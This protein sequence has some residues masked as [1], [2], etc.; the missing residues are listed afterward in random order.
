[1]FGRILGTNIKGDDGMETWFILKIKFYKYFS[2]F[3]EWLYKRGSGLTWFGSFCFRSC[4]FFSIKL[5]DTIYDYHES[6]KGVI[7]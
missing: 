2:K 4:C 3:F 7:K 1:M 6:K 5:A